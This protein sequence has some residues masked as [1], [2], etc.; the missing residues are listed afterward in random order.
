MQFPPVFGNKDRFVARTWVA[1]KTSGAKASLPQYVGYGSSN[2]EFSTIWY[3]RSFKDW[4]WNGSASALSLLIRSTGSQAGCY[5]IAFTTTH[6][7]HEPVVGWCMTGSKT[8][9]VTRETSTMWTIGHSTR[10]IDEFID[11]L[12]EHKIRLLVD[13]RRF[14][15]SRRYPHFNGADLA[16]SLGAADIAYQHMPAL[17][18][19]R[20]GRPDSA[21][22]GWRNAGLRG[23]ADHMQT[24]EFW[25]ALEGL[26]GYGMSKR[27]AIMCA[28][29]VPW[30]C[31]RW[32]ISDALLVHGWTIVHILSTKKTQIHTATAFAKQTDGRLIYPAETQHPILF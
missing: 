32:L 13:V 27:T 19:R 10:S 15:A 25:G 21:N 11:L 17:G 8:A 30:R 24:E 3:A 6:W 16:R 29:A 7:N 28:E 23:Y 4:C 1:D 14:P 26:M 20:P 9:G 5:H 31:H 12:S 2:V 18:G 22:L